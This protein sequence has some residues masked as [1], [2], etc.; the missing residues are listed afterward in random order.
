MIVKACRYS[1]VLNLYRFW[2]RI[3]SYE[4]LIQDCHYA[5]RVEKFV[6][7]AFSP[8]LFLFLT[9]KYQEFFNPSNQILA[10]DS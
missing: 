9:I 8:P 5:G 3:T 4:L 1:C 10:S 7:W 2:E 6:G